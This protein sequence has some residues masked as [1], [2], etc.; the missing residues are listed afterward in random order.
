MNP[1]GNPAVGD[2]FTPA[3]QAR[4]LAMHKRRKLVN[5]VAR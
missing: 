5:V 3:Q 2:A 4:R 1:A